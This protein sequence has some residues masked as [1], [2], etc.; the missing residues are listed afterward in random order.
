[1]KTTDSVSNPGQEPAF[2]LCVY[3]GSRNGATPAYAEVAREVGH[4]I[5]EHQGQLVY[6]GGRSGLMGVVADAA[7]EAGARVIG[8][9]PQALVD[10]E[11]AHRGCTE[12]LIV[13][14]MHERKRLMAEHSDAF[15]A[16]PGGIGTFEEFFETW[17]WRQLGY[18]NK[19]LGL[20]NHDSYYS[21]MLD[22]LGHSVN[23]GFMDEG[24]MRLI[25]VSERPAALLEKLIE[26]AGLPTATRLEEI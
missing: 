21:S 14:T 18:H 22:F 10:R 15:L 7:L 8:V 4:W 23:Q 20:L 12:L 9:I 6:G 11:H 19:P 1:M 5:G 26:R 16:L 2:S 25:E 17:T 13:D 24:Q 3:C